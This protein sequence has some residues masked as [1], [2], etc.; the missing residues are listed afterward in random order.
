MD[1]TANEI[2]H[3]DVNVQGFPTLKF[4][5]AHSK[6]KVVDYEGQREAQ[7]ILDFIH[8]NAGIKF[9]KPSL[10]QDDDEDDDDDQEL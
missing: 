5:P 6:G 9:T 8:K 2:D 4:F 1:S 10:G 7:D 3:P